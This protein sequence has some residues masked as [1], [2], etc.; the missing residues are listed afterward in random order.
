MFLVYLLMQRLALKL[1]TALQIH[2][3]YVI[4]FH[5]GGS[6]ELTQLEGLGSYRALDPTSSRSPDRMW[7]LL[8]SNI[9]LSKPATSIASKSRFF[10][11]HTVSIGLENI[12]WLESVG[13]GRFYMEPWSA[14]EIL[15]AYVDM[16]LAHHTAHVF[17]QSLVLWPFWVPAHAFP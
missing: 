9:N 5:E 4:L 13:H 6:L 8:D 16:L 17:L 14:E 3:D 2:P 10:V 15:Q 12:Q 1:P 7:V 11:V